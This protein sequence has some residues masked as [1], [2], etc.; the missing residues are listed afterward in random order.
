MRP[1]SYRLRLL[2]AVCAIV[3]FP[4]PSWAVEDAQRLSEM[5]VTGTREGELKSETPASITIL[6][7]G[8]IG[9][10]KPAHPRE[11]I[12]R[13]PGAVMMQTNGEGHTTG[14]RSP[15]GTDPVYLYLEDGI[16]TRATGFF[17]HN[18]LFEVDV[19][20]A[21]GMEIIR[22]PGSALQG[23]DAIGAVINTLTKAP[24]V[25]PE[26]EMTAE[27]GSF[28]WARL[29]ATSS[30]SWGDT[31]VRGSLNLTHTDGWR[32][33]TEYDRR[34]GTLR[35]DQA[36]DANSYLKTVVSATNASMQTG[37]NAR[38]SYVD[39]EKD[40]TLNYHSIF[41]RDVKALR[42]ST[43][44]E[45]EEGAALLSLTPYMRWNWM[46]L[47]ASFS[48]SDPSIQTTE[49]YSLGLQAKYRQDFL[50]WRTRLVS[51][52][53]L[54]HSPGSQ[55]D[56][57][58]VLKKGGE[59]Y[60]GYNMGARIYDYD[61][62]FSQAS[63]YVHAETSPV[64]AMRLSAGLRGD[65]MRYEYDNHL[66]SGSFTTTNALG[67]GNSTLYRMANSERYYSHLSPSLG[68]T[69]AFDPALNAFARYKHSFRAP[70]QS[71]LFRSGSASD[72]LHL[73]PVK[74]DT[75]EAGLRGNDKS[76]FTWE[77]TAYN[78][79]KRDDILS[80]RDTSGTTISSN[81]GKTHHKGV[82][83]A[84]GWQFLP[85]LRTDLATGYA[86]HRYATWNNSSGD[87]SGKD[88][89]SA[90][91]RVSNLTLAY[92]PKDGPLKGLWM[93][94]EWAHV[95]KYWTDDANTAMYRGHDLFNL[96]GSYEI[97]ES[98]ELFGRVMNMS[99]QKWATC[100]S[101]SSGRLE[102]CPGMP[103]TVFGGLTM[104]F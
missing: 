2:C 10:T 25:K 64:E 39:Y 50:P 11:I 36:L 98:V 99:D 55:T 92:K 77:I 87:F 93:E 72:T 49:N 89:P 86:R 38:L 63:P 41:Y 12:S 69:Y 97:F 53:D 91:D 57:R 76:P 21:G 48:T 26:T 46:Q 61:V 56:D 22:G 44:Y 96:R 5:T 9:A 43:A 18:A 13:V 29:L 78:T 37:A 58:V 83:L 16:P 66:R 59:F 73:S 47:F 80:V 81:N 30:N 67:T 62:T 24:S 6:D 104:R 45:R 1:L 40:P 35:V 74:V 84:L 60:T 54:D 32:H 68:G 88:I 34:S 101:Y 27:G 51:G 42:A 71:Q 102:Y 85:D 20:N 15:I 8:T 94:A 52:I 4:L 103:L 33:R 23:S 17:N 3:G 90:P 70:G 79:I 19:P 28:G 95:G 82:E 75:Y 14:I 7:A 65:F 100:A 31:G